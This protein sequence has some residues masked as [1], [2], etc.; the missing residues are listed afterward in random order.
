LC[1]AFVAG[2]DA[3]PIGQTRRNARPRR[4]GEWP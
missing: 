4:N 3:P 1:V 2:N